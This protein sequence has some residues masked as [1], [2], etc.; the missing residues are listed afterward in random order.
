MFS[1]E[2]CHPNR[3]QTWV[4]G[5]QAMGLPNLTEVVQA[6]VPGQ[7]QLEI[8]DLEVLKQGTLLLCGGYGAQLS[9]HDAVCATLC[10]RCSALPAGNLDFCDHCT[11]NHAQATEKVFNAA[12]DLFAML[13]NAQAVPPDGSDSQHSF[14]ID[15]AC[16]EIGGISLTICWPGGV[17][18]DSLGE[19]F[20]QDL[21]CNVTALTLIDMGITTIPEC[22]GQAFST[23]TRVDIR[24]CERLTAFPE[25][26]FELP[27][28]HLSIESTSLAS[29]PEDVG[30]RLPDGLTDLR[31]GWNRLT[32]LPNSI[33][34][35]RFLTTFSAPGN[36][37][38]DLS[39]VNFGFTSALATLDLSCNRD[40][41]GAPT[42]TVPPDISGDGPTALRSVNLRNNGLTRLPPFLR[43]GNSAILE[44]EEVFLGGNPIPP[45]PSNQVEEIRSWVTAGGRPRARFDLSL[46][47]PNRSDR[48]RDEEDRTPPPSMTQKRENPIR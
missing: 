19:H 47:P 28:S 44:L 11:L 38:T 40:G 8:L 14:R 1:I 12:I 43:S 26:L 34:D 7:P 10:E 22:W 20:V 31:L 16:D 37:F 18:P 36:Q 45:V 6:R 15:G 24:R 21:A 48:R 35:L 17:L 25:A 3:I 5:L 23:T 42:L 46:G 9:C 27:L 33:T 4:D 39:T 29:L 2:S 13:A 41:A 32:S 30:S